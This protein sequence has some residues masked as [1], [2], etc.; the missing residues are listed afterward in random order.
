MRRELGEALLGEAEEEDL[1][2]GADRED[3]IDAVLQQDGVEVGDPGVDVG[4]LQG[5]QLHELVARERG[6]GG[7]H[8]GVVGD[9]DGGADLLER[10]HDVQR[11]GLAA[12]GDQDDAVLGEGG[13]GFPR[14]RQQGEELLQEQEQLPGQGGEQGEQVGGGGGE[15]HDEGVGAA[16]GAGCGGRGLRRVGDRGCAPKRSLIYKQT[17]RGVGAFGHGR[18]EAKHSGM[19]RCLASQ[20]ARRR[21]EGRRRRGARARE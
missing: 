4:G 5:A 15:L 7:R 6:G 19:Q 3:E 16:R 17:K 2:D 11:L 1:V 14:E 9:D 8:R 13:E 12:G 21:N 20:D 10:A 18:M